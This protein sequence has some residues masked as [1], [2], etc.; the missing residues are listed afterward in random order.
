MRVVVAEG[1][2]GENSSAGIAK[3]LNTMSM[4]TAITECVCDP[5]IQLTE[6]RRVQSGKKLYFFPLLV[7]AGLYNIVNFQSLER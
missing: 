1:L 3:Y 5:C 4:R 2:L 6:L 7:T